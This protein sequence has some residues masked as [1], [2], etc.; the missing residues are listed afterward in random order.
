VKWIL[1]CGHHRAS[2]GV[3]SKSVRT[4]YFLTSQLPVVSSATSNKFCCEDKEMWVNTEFERYSVYN[5]GI[6]CKAFLR[7]ASKENPSIWIRFSH[8]YLNDI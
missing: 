2:F 8:F 4:R 1:D 5:K 7:V 3:I 6:T